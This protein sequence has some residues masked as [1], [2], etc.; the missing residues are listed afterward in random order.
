[1]HKPG[2]PV[3]KTTTRGNNTK[4]S[5]KSTL[6]RSNRLV[7]V[8]GL[9]WNKENL[10]KFGCAFRRYARGQTD[11]LVT[12]VP[13][14]KVT[15]HVTWRRLYC[16]GN[17]QPTTGGKEAEH[18]KHCD[19]GHVCWRHRAPVSCPQRTA[20]R[21]YM[22]YT[23]RISMSLWRCCTTRSLDRPTSK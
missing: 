21:I 16:I 4:H 10:V 15:Q 1:M 2:K 6:L 13:L 5:I 12:I 8:L 7:R 23:R 19:G 14:W 9:H 18:D 22:Y 17:L 3:D 20:R 11:R